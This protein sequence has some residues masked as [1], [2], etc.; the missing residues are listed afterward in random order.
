MNKDSADH[1]GCVCCRTADYPV[2]WSRLCDLNTKA[3]ISGHYLR[4]SALYTTSI[5]QRTRSRLVLCTAQI[6]NG[7]FV[8]AHRMTVRCAWLRR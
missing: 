2:G 7:G 6:T 5:W 4:E 3:L 1:G 8:M